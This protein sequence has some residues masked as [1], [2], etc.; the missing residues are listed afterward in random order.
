MFLNHSGYMTAHSMAFYSWIFQHVSPKNRDVFSYSCSLVIKFSDVRLT[1]I[2]Y[3]HL[4]SLYSN[5]VNVRINWQLWNKRLGSPWSSSCAFT[6]EGLSSVSDRGTKIPQAT[7]PKRKIKVAEAELCCCLSDPHSRGITTARGKS[8]ETRPLGMIRP[9]NP[10][11]KVTLVR[12][13]NSKMGTLL[14]IHNWK[15]LP[16]RMD[17]M[18]GLCFQVILIWWGVGG[19]D[20]WEY[21]WNKIG[22]ELI[23]VEPGWWIHHHQ[24]FLKNISFYLF[25]LGWAGSPLLLGHFLSCGGRVATLWWQLPGFSL[26]WLLCCRARALGCTSFHSCGPRGLSGC[27]SWALEH[28]LPSCGAWAQLLSGTWSLP[29]SE[30]ELCVLH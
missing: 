10:I 27:G 1:L 19:G 29:R 15:Y 30:I 9:L 17:T 4:Y 26:R 28:R 25:I 21:V 20:C 11:S 8:P 12:F 23:I 3:F 16:V 6:A 14:G 5:F 2:Q 18:S 22:H 7:R 24:L 13:L